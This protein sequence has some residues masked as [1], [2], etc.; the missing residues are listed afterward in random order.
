MAQ[1]QTERGVGAGGGQGN[2]KGGRRLGRG[3]S[4]LL[5]TPVRVDVPREEGEPDVAQGPDVAKRDNASGSHGP[6]TVAASAPAPARAEARRETPEDGEPG[7]RIEMIDVE[8]ITPNRYQPRR[9]FDAGPLKELAASIRA[10]GVVQPI[11]V[12][13]TA[14]SGGAG[15]KRTESGVEG[16]ASAAGFELVAGER[17][18]RA[19]KM[20]GLRRIPA[21]VAELSDEQAAEWALIENVQRADLKPLEQAHAVK[22]LCE[23]FGLSHAD[24]AEKL[25]L[26]RSTV[27]NLI[28]L[29]EL[30]PQIQEWIERGTLTIGHGKALLAIGSSK[31][32]MALAKRAA[33]AGWSVRT[34]NDAIIKSATDVLSGKTT[35]LDALA[36]AERRRGGGKGQSEGALAAAGLIELEKQLSEHLGTR[37][38]IRVRAGGKKGS[39]VV[40]FYDLDQF[41]GLMGKMGFVMR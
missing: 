26:D 37:V 5:G 17:R 25:G 13:R 41:D 6:A 2:E 23:R 35:E 21:V 18:W 19:S 3:L 32:R 20:A 31:E 7:S 12:R 36:A 11:L 16:A 9:A 40:Q 38:K 1:T 28:R 10:A 27:S 15:G 39:V 8:A 29:T 30:E 24:A 33:E 34:I 22:A 14:E 4:S